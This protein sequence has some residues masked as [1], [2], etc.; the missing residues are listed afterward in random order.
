MKVIE[1]IELLKKL[2]PYLEDVEYMIFLDNWEPSLFE[3]MPAIYKDRFIKTLTLEEAIELLPS[4]IYWDN[5]QKLN[6]YYKK[7][8]EE[9]VEYICYLKEFKD[10][11][12][13]EFFKSKTL[14]QAIEKML[15]YLID[16]D[17]LWL[18]NQ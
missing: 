5:W 4:Y 3:E 8:D 18:W 2:Q 14:L 9:E 16:N 7:E 6:I 12:A 13:Y 11:R 17:L 10:L 1:N 15:E